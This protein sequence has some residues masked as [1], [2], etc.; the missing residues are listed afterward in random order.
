MTGSVGTLY[1]RKYYRL[2]GVIV[3]KAE[4]EPERL[5]YNHGGYWLVGGASNGGSYKRGY[6]MRKCETA[7][8]INAVTN[9]HAKLR[10]RVLRRTPGGS[11]SN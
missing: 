8:L 5:S 1:V 7:H 2:H 3:N 10:V 6:K 11:N 9:G 4:L